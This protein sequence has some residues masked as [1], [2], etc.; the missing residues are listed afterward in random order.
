MRTLASRVSRAS[1]REPAGG[2][3]AELA[4]D[5]AAVEVGVVA[6]DQLVGDRQDV[7]ALDL[8]ARAVGANPWN[9]P[10][11]ANVPRARHRTATRPRPA[12]VSSTSNRKSG[13]AANSSLKYWRTP[14]GRGQLP[15]ADE[16]LDARREPSTP[17]R[18]RGRASAAAW[19]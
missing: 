18:R 15:L 2:R 10:G 16:P 4:R 19:K 12:V 14:V 6:L 1:A 11:P 7:A 17:P 13:N 9:A 5:V 8:D 3:N